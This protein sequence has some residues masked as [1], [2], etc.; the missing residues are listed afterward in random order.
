MVKQLEHG[1]LHFSVSGLVV[2]ESFGSDCIDF[3][4][5][6]DRRL[7]FFSQGKGIPDHFGAVSDVHLNEVGSGQFQKT[8]FGLSCAGSGH[9]GL[10]GSGRAEHQTTFR[11]PDSDVFE[12]FFVCDRQDNGFS[13][14]FDLFIQASD[15]GVLFGGFFVDFHGLDPGVV[16]GREFLEQNIGILVDSD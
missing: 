13:E 7:F 15:I 14:L 4:D 12:F 6:D 10:S 11:R 16:L 9:H 2:I 1:P 8:G 5:E 3:I